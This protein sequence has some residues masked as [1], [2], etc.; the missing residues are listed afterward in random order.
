[1]R[2]LG[3]AILA[4]CAAQLLADNVFARAGALSNPT[5]ITIVDN[6]NASLYP[7]T[8]VVPGSGA[9]TNVSVSLIGFT[10]PRVS[11]LTVLLVAPSGRKIQMLA[12]APG[13]AS[14]LSFL[15]ISD[16]GRPVAG[17][18]FLKVPYRCTLIPGPEVMPAPA[19]GLPYDTSFASLIGEE[20]GGTWSLFV[21][22][23]VSGQAG[24][25]A[26]GWT[27]SLNEQPISPVHSEFSYQGV[28]KENGVAL[29]G[30]FDVKADLWR[31][32][33]SV[34]PGDLV[35]SSTSL[36][37]AVSN[38]VFSTRFAPSES[39]L[40]DGRA[41]WV[42]LSVKGPG[43]AAFV[44][45][46]PREPIAATPLA[47]FALASESS[48][49][50][51]IAQSVAFQN[52]SGVPSN[53]ANAFSPWQDAGANSIFFN[54]A[55]SVFIG[56]TTGSSKLT[57]NGR[58]ESTN[59][60]V[61]FPDG[62]VQTTAATPLQIIGSKSVT[63]TLG[64]IAAG[65]ELNVGISFTGTSFETTDVVVVSPSGNLPTDVGIQYARVVSATS[66]Q[67][68]LRNHGAGVANVPSL[69]YTV[70]VIR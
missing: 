64:N 25:I 57:V 42:E 59:G 53:V 13:A 23:N 48:E 7:S 55:G 65:A 63:T 15:A 26:G 3:L 52:V 50:A 12:H 62:T 19:P 39:V 24:L 2:T 6:A 35:A 54:T 32:P 17:D 40:T 28:L 21:R 9:I 46:S 10:H 51:E 1:M 29:N 56:A 18:Q 45:L 67:F 66:V 44:K 20:G 11:D 27:L 4:A 38:G 43:D 69:T 49:F 41:L 22:D 58:L 70:K 5:P 60:G 30:L 31:S 33:I 61:K 36:G 47:A 68:K 8:I 14:A 16:A 37:V 34:I